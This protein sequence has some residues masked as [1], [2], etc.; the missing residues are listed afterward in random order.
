MSE[1]AKKTIESREY[2][3]SCKI[4][5]I[6]KTI[7]VRCGCF[8]KSPD[9]FKALENFKDTY[10][11]AYVTTTYKSR[12]DDKVVATEVAFV[13]KIT[14]EKIVPVV[15]TSSVKPLEEK[16]KKIVTFVET[17]DELVI[18][19][20]R[21]TNKAKQKKEKKLKKK[22]KKKL[23]KKK[24]KSKKKKKNNS[25]YV[26]KRDEIANYGRFLDKLESKKANGYGYKYKFGAQISYD[27]VYV[28]EADTSYIEND[29]RRIRVYHKGS[30]DHEKLFYELEYSFTG[31]NQYKDILVGYKDTLRS[32]ALDYRVKIGNIKIPFSLE[33]YSSSKNITF[34][35]RALTDAFADNRKLG[36]EL[37]LSQNIDNSR[38]NLFSSVFTN[39][40]DEKI[41][42]EVSKPGYSFRGTYS[43]KF[44]KRHLFSIGGAY[45]NRDMKGEDV[46]INQSAE[47]DF[48]HQKY[49]SVTVKEVQT[50]TKSNIEAIY[51]YDKYSLAAEYTQM[52]LN[53]YNKLEYLNDYSFDAYYVEGSY[54]IK[55]RGKRY[56]MYQSRYK[57]IKPKIGGAVELAFR[58]SYIN[59]N[60]TSNEKKE[61]GGT[62]TD[63]NF[64][65]NWYVNRELR[66]FF[67]YIISE[68]KGTEEYDGRL[69]IAQARAL[70]AF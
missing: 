23:K 63:Y 66:L 26:K 13:E 48:I 40:I 58:Y 38:V 9:A 35:E 59:L 67:N 34:M 57:K 24:K 39:S 53:A 51:M 12:F 5:E 2:D 46:K 70:F 4:M 65:I 41:D 61:L 55:G 64:G 18:V 10:K 31:A 52:K 19:G 11:K 56:D 30:F 36:A 37:L 15:I 50:S 68:P 28:D 3:S 33:T 47:S 25:K 8:E 27:V 44:R 62:Q 69:Q 32:F 22:K 45:M 17:P 60:D 43:Y 20:N 42:D 54:F 21:A 49:L 14:P 16:S 7:T 6:G 1:E 29:Y